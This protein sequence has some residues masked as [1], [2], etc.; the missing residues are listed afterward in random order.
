MKNS[1]SIDV[2]LSFGTIMESF[3]VAS[4]WN[5]NGLRIIKMPGMTGRGIRDGNNLY[6]HPDIAERIHAEI[7][8]IN[9]EAWR[10]GQ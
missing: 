10:I 6:V 4:I 9:L 5:Y 3:G 2:K 7:S 1:P 8:R